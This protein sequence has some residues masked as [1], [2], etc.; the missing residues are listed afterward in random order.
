MTEPLRIDCP[1]R[2][3]LLSLS[4]IRELATDEHHVVVLLDANARKP[5]ILINLAKALPDFAVFDSG[6]HRGKEAITIK[7]VISSKEILSNAPE[8]V[9]TA[10]LF[11]VTATYLAQTLSNCL[12]VKPADLIH[13]PK[14]KG[15]L[16]REWSYGFHGLEC[17][18]KNRKTGQELNVRLDFC[19]EFGVLD[20]SFFAQFIKTTPAFFN[21]ARHLK[22]D[23]HDT[24]RVF[25]LLT[26]TGNL[27]I[28]TF[29]SAAGVLV[30]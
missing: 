29:A 7:K 1:S 2:A 9:A 21:T 23:F 15:R 13:A 19:D 27:R 11:R 8:F 10:R 14:T 17:Y 25:E 12:G 20:P 26:E 6:C 4:R 30:Q 22:D 3:E 16:N 24:S 18:F 5:E 28:V